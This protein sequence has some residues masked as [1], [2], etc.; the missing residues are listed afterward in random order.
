[1]RRF[2]DHMN[3]TGDPWSLNRVDSDQLPASNQGLLGREEALIKRSTQQKKAVVSSWIVSRLG[4]GGPCL[5]SN[6]KIR[7]NCSWRKKF[8]STESF[9]FCTA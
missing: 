8:T 9:K 7:K 4:R 1:M 3:G 2:S 5:Q 6:T